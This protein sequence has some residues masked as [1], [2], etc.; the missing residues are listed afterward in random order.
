MTEPP[1]ALCLAGPTATGKT[2]LSF[3]LAGQLPI[4][5]ISV[6]SAMIYRSMDIGTAKPSLAMRSQV[7]HHLIDIRDPTQTYSAGRFAQDAEALIKAIR[8]RNRVPV[9]IGGTLLYFRALLSGLAPLPLGD[10]ASRAALDERAARMGW[11]ALHAELKKIDPTAAARI[12]P[13]DRQRIQRSLEI[14]QLTGQTQTQ[15]LRATPAKGVVQCRCFALL[16]D[17]RNT[18]RSRI[19]ERFEQMLADGLVEEVE[20]LRAMPGMQADLPSARALGYRQ[21]WQHLDGHLQFDEAVQRAIVATR[22]YAKRQMTW[23]RG[24]PQFSPLRMS[25]SET[26]QPLLKA[27]RQVLESGANSSGRG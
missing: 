21:I 26:V 5:I 7:P 4:E 22:R 19:A 9:L 20:R 24:E 13:N 8:A 23:L 2:Q 10:A 3:D 17:D 27:A 14:Y 18:L 15:L 6:D 11:P 1:R 12:E 16:P 25:S